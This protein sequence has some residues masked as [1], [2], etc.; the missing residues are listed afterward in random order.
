MTLPSVGDDHPLVFGRPA[1][2]YFL[3]K[4]H[5]AIGQERPYFEVRS[6]DGTI[7]RFTSVGPASG[8]YGRR[9]WRIESSTDAYDNTTRYVYDTSGRLSLISHPQGIEERWNYHPSWISAG[10]WD[11]DYYSGIEITFHDIRVSPPA[12]MSQKAQAML[13]RRMRTETG[14]VAG[15]R[16]LGGDYLYRV[17]LGTGQFLDDIPQGQHDTLYAFDPNSPPPE[18][19]AVRQYEYLANTSLVTSVSQFVADSI[20]IHFGCRGTEGRWKERQTRKV[21]R[22]RAREADKGFVGRDRNVDADASKL[23]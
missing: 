2:G 6:V 19:R 8:T 4:F 17:Y 15:S 14:P 21:Q 10:Q 5:N 20:A 23:S 11:P 9:R 3:Y 1:E 16:P 22:C 7:Q 12:A 18:R 13:F